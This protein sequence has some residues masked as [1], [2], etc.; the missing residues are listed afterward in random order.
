MGVIFQLQCFT[1]SSGYSARLEAG[2]A[3][4]KVCYHLTTVME[5]PRKASRGDIAYPIFKSHPL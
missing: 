2:V 3:L 4:A 5:L 1:W